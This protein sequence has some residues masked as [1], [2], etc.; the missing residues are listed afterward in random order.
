MV[1]I[2][3]TLAQQ[4]VKSVRQAKIMIK[5]GQTHQTHAWIVYPVRTANKSDNAFVDIVKWVNLVIKPVPHSH[6]QIA[7]RA[8]FCMQTEARN[9]TSVLEAMLPR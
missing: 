4:H 9:V 8:N 1:S 2:K 7:T 6:V 5:S 3:T